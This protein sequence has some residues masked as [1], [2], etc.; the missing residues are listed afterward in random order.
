MSRSARKPKS[1]F[2]T[3]LGTAFELVKTLSDE[4]TSLGGNDD[5]LR[6]IIADK[7]V[8]RQIA[9]LLVSRP[10]SDT[11]AL[12]IN[13]TRSLETMVALGRYEY[14]NGDITAE[15]FPVGSG[16]AS[17]EAV[18]VHLNRRASDEEVLAELQQY[19]LRPATMA[20]LAAFGEQYPDQ[21]CK[22]LIVALGSVGTDHHGDRSVGC[23]VGRPLVGRPPYRG[24][25]VFPL[26]FGW[27]E[28]GRFL[29]V[30]K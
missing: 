5:D 18:L 14:V 13:Y 3:G 22:Y 7:S 27:A 16:E 6:R 12:D 8:A 29:A 15:N 30:R 1:E 2:V 28:H 21:Q 17:V 23:L 11:F 9:E 19:G 10:V 4:V 24:L 25:N 20:E 26:G